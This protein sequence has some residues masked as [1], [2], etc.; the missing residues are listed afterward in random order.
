MLSP[1]REA[2]VR[3]VGGTAHTHARTHARTHAHA[4]A[5]THTN[6]I[7]R[8]VQVLMV[9]WHRGEIIQA[10]RQDAAGAAL[11]HRVYRS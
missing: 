1:S 6:F 11:L 5:R 7:H 3:L 8:T 2:R 4:R 10:F 9:G